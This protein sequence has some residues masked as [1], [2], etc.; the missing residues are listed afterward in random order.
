M[1]NNVGKIKLELTYTP[2]Q[3]NIFFESNSRR[4]VITKGRR[5]GLT[6][7]MSQAFIEWMLE[8]DRMMM[9]GDT[10]HANIDRYVERY[11]LPALKQLPKKL[12]SWKKQAKQ[13]MIAGS[14]C[15]F[16]S[17]DNPENWEGF[18][19]HYIF[20]NE[21]GII[22]KNRYLYE[23][24]V[25]PMLLDFPDSTAIIGGTPKGKNLFYEL[26]LNGLN[27]ELADWESFKFSTY[28]NPFLSKKDVDA[29]ISE[30]PENAVRQEIYGDFIDTSENQFIDGEAVETAS[31]KALS[32]SMYDRAV[33]IIGVDVAR[34]GSD[35]SVICK[36][37]GLHAYPLKKL[38]DID[39]MTL[40][41]IV[42]SEINTFQP[43]GVFVDVGAMGAGVIDRL[44]QL[45]HDVIEVNF[46]SRALDDKRYSN[47]RSE[48]WGKMRDW[49]YAGGSIPDDRELRSDL[50]GPTYN[51]DGTERIQLEKKDEMKRRGLSSPD[52][53]DALALTFAAPVVQRAVR[54]HSGPVNTDYDP[55]KI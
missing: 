22:L 27:P 5:L 46:G 19:Y 17:A 52:G 47:R 15:D 21:A 8:K 54:M 18:G 35:R 33:K 6:Q 14:V 12:W 10:V 50:V 16:R 39:T 45:G 41:D 43:D 55:L 30:L 20:L 42:A 38:S 9:W 36:R 53:A 34:F 40:A 7:G 3:E 2:C 48:M 29:M 26:Y 24:A 13:L 49:L 37:Q 44:R 32:E 28:D 1:S 23:N 4:R 31:G 51:F 25:R 11:F